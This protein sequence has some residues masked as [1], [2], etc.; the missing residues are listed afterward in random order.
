MNKKFILNSSNKWLCGVC[1]GI[2]E[3]F[4]CDP[5]IVRLFMLF[6]FWCDCGITLPIY[7]LIALFAPKN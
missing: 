4:D 6:S 1:G 5:F 3:Y 7:L 2:A